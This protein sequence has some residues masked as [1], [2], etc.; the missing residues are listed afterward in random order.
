MKLIIISLIMLLFSVA[1]ALFFTMSR[2]SVSK[3]YQQCIKAGGGYEAQADTSTCT[4]PNSQEQ[5]TI[6]L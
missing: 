4:W 1:S 3:E 2:S 5:V 6:D